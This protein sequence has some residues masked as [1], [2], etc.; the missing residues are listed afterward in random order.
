MLLASL[1]LA[2]SVDA[3]ASSPPASALTDAEYADSAHLLP[4]GRAAVH[5]L[6]PSAIAVG[7]HLDLSSDL[8]EDLVA[9]NLSMKI[10]LVER[11]PLALALEPEAHRSWSG[12]AGAV[13][14]TGRA[15][16]ALGHHHAHLG[17]GVGWGT[18]Q[19]PHSAPEHAPQAPAA[20]PLG[21]RVLAHSALD[22]VASDA[23]TWRVVV[24]TGL[25]T[26]GEGGQRGRAGLRWAHALSRVARVCAGADLVAGPAS[27][28]GSLARIDALSA[29]PVL[30]APSE[31]LLHPAAHLDLWWLL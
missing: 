6:G 30:P 14:A 28:W 25:A 3:V 5:L 24:E 11:G 20:P 8:L 1:V 31:G 19:G 10:G 2:L 15:T 13:G 27:P 26:A 18:P 4:H 12:G 17:L 7:R 29:H 23:T 9:P 21:L 22:L 16:V